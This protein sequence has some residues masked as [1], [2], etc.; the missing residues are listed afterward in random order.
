MLNELPN[1]K[2]EVP[3]LLIRRVKG[4]LL[5][6]EELQEFVEDLKKLKVW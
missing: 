5:S 2:I 6:K 1:L 4:S 3:Y